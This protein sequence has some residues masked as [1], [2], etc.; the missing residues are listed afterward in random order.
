MRTS[1]RNAG[2]RRGRALGYGGLAS[3]TVTAPSTATV[4]SRNGPNF[5][6]PATGLLSGGPTDG[7]L[8][9]VIFAGPDRVFQTTCAGL[10][11]GGTAQ[12]DDYVAT[13]STS[14]TNLG[15][16]ISFARPPLATEAAL[17]ALATTRNAQCNPSCPGLAPL[18][19]RRT[20]PHAGHEHL[21]AGTA[22]Q[23][24]FVRVEAPQL[25]Q[26]AVSTTLKVTGL[27]TLTGGLT[28]TGGD[29]C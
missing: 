4:R 16:G 15:S 17:T 14:Q 10:Q 8:L 18:D 13:M 23:I 19:A 22:G 2:W 9:A 21:C 26:L 20:A 5:A 7:L 27:T 1:T 24:K 3:W 6:T 11:A 25:S 12:G 28:T 29:Q